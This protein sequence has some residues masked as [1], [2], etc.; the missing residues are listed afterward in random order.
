MERQLWPFIFH[1]RLPDQDQSINQP[2][3]ITPSH[4][5]VRDRKAF[6]VEQCRLGGMK[7][8]IFYSLSRCQHALYVYGLFDL[9]NHF[10]LINSPHICLSDLARENLFSHAPDCYWP[11]KR[12]IVQPW[13]E[14]TPLYP[15]SS[16][17]ITGA[18]IP[19]DLENRPAK[20]YIQAMLYLSTFYDKAFKEGNSL[21]INAY[22]RDIERNFCLSP[23]EELKEASQMFTAKPNN[24]S[25]PTHY[26]QL[27]AGARLITHRLCARDR[28]LKD[29][30]LKGTAVWIYFC[31]DYLSCFEGDLLKWIE[32]PNIASQPIASI[33]IRAGNERNIEKENYIKKWIIETFEQRY[34][35][36]PTPSKVWVASWTTARDLV[37]KRLVHLHQGKAYVTYADVTNWLTGAYRQEIEYFAEKD[38]EIFWNPLQDQGMRHPAYRKVGVL[39]SYEHLK[40]TVRQKLMLDSKFVTLPVNRQREVF[41]LQLK[42][43]RKQAKWNMKQDRRKFWHPALYQAESRLVYPYFP[44]K[45]DPA[46]AVAKLDWMPIRKKIVSEKVQ[47]AARSSATNDERF[48]NSTVAQQYAQALEQGVPV[49]EAFMSTYASILP[50]CMRMPLE[51]AFSKHGHLQDKQRWLFFQ[52]LAYRRVPLETAKYLWKDLCARDP[53]ADWN[54]LRMYPK[55]FYKGWKNYENDQS[56]YKGGF[57]SCKT[58]I[59]KYAGCCPF[60][61]SDI[62]DSID[63]CAQHLNLA[64]V[65]HSYNRSWHSPG[66]AST[67][68]ERGIASSLSASSSSSPTLTISYCED[69]TLDLEK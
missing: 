53:D 69:D 22:M 44:G 1:V 18:V 30:V 17:K 6:Y 67:H 66:H 7:F 36:R 3:S 61:Q 52:F 23:P 37:A 39:T 9:Y 29:L 50:P 35:N 5:V 4:C 10:T 26:H 11:E 38:Q 16:V 63:S 8:V 25:I 24:S 60:A 41:S 54:E 65:S 43:A 42:L 12:R 31:F 34:P 45:F 15:V 20:H 40:H 2:L 46:R 55:H 64:A 13:D 59:T 27:F 28:I 21:I 51:Q 33:Q 58:V 68:M 57:V 49:L 47:Q 32:I 48:A 62:E 14:D 19:R 56:Q